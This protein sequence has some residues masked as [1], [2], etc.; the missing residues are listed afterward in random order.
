MAWGVQ[1]GIRWPQAARLQGVE[2]SGMAGP[3]ENLGS[4]WNTP[5]HMPM[6]EDTIYHSLK[7]IM[8]LSN[9]NMARRIPFTG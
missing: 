8:L 5:C 2:G 3:G 6:K 7:S 1:G 9:L 4:P